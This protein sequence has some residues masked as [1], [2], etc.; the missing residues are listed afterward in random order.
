MEL[1]VD[2]K[3]IKV[4]RLNKSW[5][6]EELAEKAALSL[7]T[8][9]RMELDGSASLKSRR[10]VAN[11]LEVE[12]AY[13]DPPLAKPLDEVEEY[14]DVDLTIPE[15]GFWMDLL[16]YPGPNI[17]SNKIRT[18][19]LITLWLGMMITGGLVLLIVGTITIL[20][21]LSPS[22]FFSQILIASLPVFVIFVVCFGLYSFFK[23]FNSPSS[24]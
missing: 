1:K 2:H 24:N 14:E 11:A 17:L 6:Q 22:I 8:V 21:F 19:L 3:K 7:R 20:N 13:L 23:R 5:S 16:A 18:P 4:L 10:A 15:K 12:P 9:Q